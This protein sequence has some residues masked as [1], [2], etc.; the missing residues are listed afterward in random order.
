MFR[1]TF[2]THESEKET[3]SLLAEHQHPGDI[4]NLGDQDSGDT[5]VPKSILKVNINANCNKCENLSPNHQTFIVFFSNVAT[6]S[7][8]DLTFLED[9]LLYK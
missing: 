9:Q 1:F 6:P 3:N 7:K 4:N 2:S 5:N 8:S